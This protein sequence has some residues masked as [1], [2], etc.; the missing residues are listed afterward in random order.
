MR[1][2]VLAQCVAEGWPH[3]SNES[4][5]P[6]MFIRIV[7]EGLE[8]LVRAEV[9]LPEEIG[10]VSFDAPSTTWSAALARPT[11]NLFL[12]D[13]ARSE[14]TNRAP[15][16]RVDENGTRQRRA[17]QP[18][19][20]LSYL[21]SAWADN[22]RDEHQLL[23]EV[24][25]RFAGMEILP[26]EYLPRALSSS[27]HLSLVDQNQQQARDIWSGAGGALKAAFSLNATVAADTFGWTQEP[28]LITSIEGSMRAGS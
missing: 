8:R 14:H 16:R 22:P 19:I 21:V 27:V 15:T 2:T 5:E 28:P 12:Y 13:L 20:Q 26:P 9:P 7:D 1:D 25:S 3:A 11:V 17:P 18:M 4:V 24:I 23:G 6:M 10:D